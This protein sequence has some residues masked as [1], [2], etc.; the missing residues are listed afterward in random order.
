MDVL[1]IRLAFQASI[2]NNDFNTFKKY[3]NYPLYTKGYINYLNGSLINRAT[4]KCLVKFVKLIIEDDR[5]DPSYNGSECL[6]VACDMGNIEITKII[7]EH[8]KAEPEKSE[9]LSIWTANEAGHH[10]IVK[11]LWNEKSIKN[12]LQKDDP[13]L[14]HELIVLD[15]HKKMVSF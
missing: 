7:I 2:N 3:L 15:T 10:D 11:L 1:D 14:Y 5:F 8:P 4:R 13:D 12:T 6:A 9:N